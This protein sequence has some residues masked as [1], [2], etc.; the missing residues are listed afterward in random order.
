M[1]MFPSTSAYTMFKAGTS[2]PSSAA[3]NSFRFFDRDIPHSAALSLVFSRPVQQS[4]IARPSRLMIGPCTVE[5]ITSSRGPSPRT[6]MR[7][8]IRAIF[9]HSPRCL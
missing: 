5:S 8:V 4:E 1:A 7:S 2:R 9:F 6:G 3:R